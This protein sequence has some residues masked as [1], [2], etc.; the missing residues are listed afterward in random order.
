MIQTQAYS[1]E[2]AGYQVF[3][4]IKGEKFNRKLR[5]HHIILKIADNNNQQGKGNFFCFSFC[6]LS[7]IY[8]GV[9]TKSNQ[10]VNK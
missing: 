7:K 3:L 1:A 2:R 5:F 4:P 9:V 8:I 6:R 10:F